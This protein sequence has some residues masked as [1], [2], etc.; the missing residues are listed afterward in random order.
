MAAKAATHDRFQPDDRFGIF[1]NCCGNTRT[2][3][4]KN[5][6]ECLPWVAAFAA[7]TRCDWV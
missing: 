6:H 1:F 3:K 2:T 7:M 5:T 4:Q